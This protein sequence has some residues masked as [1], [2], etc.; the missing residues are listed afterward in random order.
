[1][2]RNAAHPR[3]HGQ[4]GA[5]VTRGVGGNAARRSG[6]I[7]VEH[8]IECTPRLEGADFLQVFAF[9]IHFAASAFV[10]QATVNDR[11]AVDMGSNARVGGTDL[12]EPDANL[13]HGH[14]VHIKSPC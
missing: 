3:S 7:E 2:G 5:V 4:G 6:F 11:C 10:Q 12:I 9:E 14:I 1:M 13:S 8:G